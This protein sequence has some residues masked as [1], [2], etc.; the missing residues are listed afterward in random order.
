MMWGT[1]FD[2]VTVTAYYYPDETWTEDVMQ[3]YGGTIT[4]V[5]LSKCEHDFTEWM[6]IELDGVTYRIRACKK[7][8]YIETDLPDNV[9]HLHDWRWESKD[10][11]CTEP[12]YKDYI[13]C[14]NCDLA[15][16]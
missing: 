14:N 4:W 13:W 12:G 3:D 10:P 9:A 1:T 8:G 11:T 6:P 5:A 16:S 7:C 2:Q 15:V